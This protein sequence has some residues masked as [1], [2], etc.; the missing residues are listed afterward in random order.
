VAKSVGYNQQ[1]TYITNIKY[2]V[3]SAEELTMTTIAR[4]LS[5][6]LF[7]LISGCNSNAYKNNPDAAQLLIQQL[8]DAIEINKEK[9]AISYC[10][11]NTCDS[12]TSKDKS[13]E[14][15][16]KLSD[17]TYIYLLHFSGYIY[18]EDFKT[19]GEEYIS[20]IMVRNMNTCPDI[21]DIENAKCILRTL[22]KTYSIEITFIRYDEG[23]RWEVPIDLES[24][25][26]RADK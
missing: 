18:L 13:N 22:A 5:L 10:P 8:G 26:R 14:S 25:L 9:N 7:L 20:A 24:E 19:S 11:D 16:N 2:V 3:C 1:L 17:F 6:I 15:L 4:I 12:F 23:G 21:N